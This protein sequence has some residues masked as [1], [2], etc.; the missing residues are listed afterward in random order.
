MWTDLV[1]AY[2]SKLAVLEEARAAYSEAVSEVIAETGPGMEAAVR[3][4]LGDDAARYRIEAVVTSSGSDA[5]FPL[6]PWSYI[7]IADDVVGTEFRISSW[8]ASSW[9][10][11]TGLLRVVL[12]LERVHGSLD[13]KEWVSRCADLIEDSTPGEPFDPLDSEKFRDTSSDWPLIRIAS[14][15]L[16]G[17]DSRQAAKEACA[18]AQALIEAVAPALDLIRD[19][20]LAW[21]LA[22]DALL[23]YRPTL[24][25]RAKQVDRPVYPVR[26]LGSWQGG[27]YLQVGDF[28][29]ATH[30]ASGALLA[31]C[32]R[33]DE[34]IVVGLAEQLERPATRTGN[35]PSVVLI[36]EEQLR[37]PEYD[38][39]AA[40]R[41]AFEYW[42][43]ARS[44]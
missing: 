4:G 35:S 33:P 28:W 10:G 38:T 40:V 44:Q 34:E 23:R 5:P 41:M 27:N 39:D 14:I 21:T 31:A 18:A 6:A 19:A 26:A 3:R 1:Q 7:T 37:D 30:P 9:G 20:G 36:T 22:E 32:N 11:P 24:E 42:F 12:S 25:A 17:Q 16:E 13:R 2:E 29:L 8:V 15:E 43:E